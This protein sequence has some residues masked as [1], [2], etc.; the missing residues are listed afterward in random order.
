MKLFNYILI[1]SILFALT[2]SCQKSEDDF[3][4]PELSTASANFELKDSLIS[5]KSEIDF[6][7]DSIVLSAKL[8]EKVNWKIKLEGVESGAKKEFEGLSDSLRVVWSGA[9]D[10]IFHFRTKE[11]VMATL[12]VLA[13]KVSDTTLIIID[14][15]KT[16][17]GYLVNDY[18][19]EGLT[20]GGWWNSFKPGELIAFSNKYSGIKPPQGKNCIFMKGIDLGPDKFLGQTGHPGTYDYGEEEGFPEANENLFFNYYLFLR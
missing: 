15:T 6:T 13:S 12:T 10:N 1:A 2:V 7:K 14:K 18:D 3:F 9:S 8:S 16:F 4:G 19:G 5:S 17:E 11:Q 20:S